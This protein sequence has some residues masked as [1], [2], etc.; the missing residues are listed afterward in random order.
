MQYDESVGL[1]ALRL[2]EFEGDQARSHD[3]II[4]PDD[5]CSFRDGL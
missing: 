5:V 3:A 4:M 2:A 1:V